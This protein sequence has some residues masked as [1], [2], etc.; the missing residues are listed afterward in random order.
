MLATDRLTKY[1]SF[2]V[3]RAGDVCNTVCEN[4]RRRCGL[5]YEALSSDMQTTQNHCV[6][7]GI[8]TYVM[9]ERNKFWC[10]A[11]G[12]FTRSYVQRADIS[13]ALKPEARQNNI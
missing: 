4:C 13:V 3:H 12:A 11:E 6:Y 2:D 7:V 9:H 1:A 10:Q 5:P 8:Q